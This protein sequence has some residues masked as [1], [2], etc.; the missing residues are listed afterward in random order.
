MPVVKSLMDSL[1]ERYGKEKGERVYYAMEAEGKGPFG[2]GGKHHDK[3]KA[4]A[5]KNGVTPASKKKTP[6]SKK[7]GSKRRR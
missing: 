4:W 7:R 1:V 3:H 6:A 2:P 5:A